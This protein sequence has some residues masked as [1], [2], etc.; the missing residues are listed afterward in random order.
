MYAWRILGN[1]DM[2]RIVKTDLATKLADGFDAQKRMKLD[3][4]MAYIASEM[5]MGDIIILPNGAVLSV[6]FTPALSV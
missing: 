3:D 6:G 4:A 5:H 1:E 2:W